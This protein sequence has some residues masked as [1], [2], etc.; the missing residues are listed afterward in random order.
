VSNLSDNLAIEKIR[1]TAM[2]DLAYDILKRK[3]EPMLYQNIM[4]EVANMKEFTEED[5]EKYI[6]Q[7]YTEVNIDGRFICVGRSLWGLRAWYPTEQATDSAVAANVK[8]DYIDD[9][10]EEIFDEEKEYDPV[11]DEIDDIGDY[12]DDDDFEDELD[13]D[14]LPEEDEEDL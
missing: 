4:R 5:I 13:S 6:A 1:E 8:D 3:G 7:L 10:E 11:L 9:E 2:V 12:A 14:D